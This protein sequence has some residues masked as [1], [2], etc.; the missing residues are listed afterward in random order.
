MSDTANVVEIFSS[1]QGEG[2]YVGYR[3][4]FVRFFSCNLECAYCDTPKSLSEVRTCLIERTPGE[5]DFYHL[6]N[7]LDI[8]T[9]NDIISSFEAVPGLNH[10]ISLTGGEPLL[11]GKF[12]GKWL[13]QLSQNFKIYLETNGTLYNELKDI[14]DYIDIISMDI[15]LPSAALIEPEWDRHLRFLKI[16]RQARL[17]VKIVLSAE[18]ADGEFMRA[19]DMLADIDMNI[20][21]ILQP[22]TPYA[23]VQGKLSS[24]RLLNFHLMARRRLNDVRIIPQTHKMM[25][26]L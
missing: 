19:L 21:L 22:V 13:P 6:P 24:K 12:L 26:L 3:Q 7:P 16:A 20:P 2:V 23:G 14:I 15:K 5:G 25:N 18:T 1:I 17:F 8:K 9:L 4:I 11:Q 10:S